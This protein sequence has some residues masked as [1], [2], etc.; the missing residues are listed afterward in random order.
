[1]TSFQC[2]LKDMDKAIQGISKM[3][4]PNRGVKGPNESHLKYTM[5]QPIT[6]M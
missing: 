4:K 3:C 2:D 1:M 6:Q 5:K